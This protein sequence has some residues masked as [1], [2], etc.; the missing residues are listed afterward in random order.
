M[1]P[2]SRYA[3][4]AASLALAAPVAGAAGFAFTAQSRSVAV[5]ISIG[6]PTA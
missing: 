5:T 3:G 4:L 1:A 6:R 2:W